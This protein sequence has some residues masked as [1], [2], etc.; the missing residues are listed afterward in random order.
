MFAGASR[1]THSLQRDKNCGAFLL[2]SDVCALLILE[3]F[4]KEKEGDEA[5]WVEARE[6]EMKRKRKK[7]RHGIN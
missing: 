4:D 1:N 3:Q 6:E 5:L 7:K 2:Q